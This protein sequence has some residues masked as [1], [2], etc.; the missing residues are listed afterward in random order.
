MPYGTSA[1]PQL[2]S[3]GGDDG[4]LPQAAAEADTTT[5]P[6]IAFFVSVDIRSLHERLGDHT[7][8]A[9]S[10]RYF[11]CLGGACVRPFFESPEHVRADRS[12]AWSNV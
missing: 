7:L 1:F 8:I 6:Q 12:C 11:Q 9:N 2:Q 4:E 3:T 10:N 5:N